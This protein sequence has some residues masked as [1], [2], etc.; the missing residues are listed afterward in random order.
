MLAVP[1]GRHE[2]KTRNTKHKAPGHIYKYGLYSI[3]YMV[4]V[5]KKIFCPLCKSINIIPWSILLY[6]P[7]PS[8]FSGHSELLDAILLPG[9]S[10][11]KRPGETAGKEVSDSP[12]FSHRNLTLSGTA[13]W[14]FLFS[15]LVFLNF[16]ESRPVRPSESGHFIGI[17]EGKRRRRRRRSVG[18]RRGATPRQVRQ[19]KRRGGKSTKTLFFSLSLSLSLSILFPSVVAGSLP[20]KENNFLFYLFLIW[21]NF[22]QFRDFKKRIVVVYFVSHFVCTCR[23]KVGFRDNNKYKMTSQVKAEAAIEAGAAFETL[24]QSYRRE[25]RKITNCE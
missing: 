7:R 9:S 11:G 15:F 4:F 22:R 21:P 6:F 2:K 20:E 5:S 8:S 14:L 17:V 13:R 1:K 16:F 23:E 10:S 3:R 24:Q 12:T 18:R 25:I 19:K